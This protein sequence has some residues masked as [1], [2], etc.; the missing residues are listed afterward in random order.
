ML[1][2]T[3]VQGS[4]I[5]PMITKQ[6]GDCESLQEL[7]D[8]VV[9]WGGSF[10]PINTAAAFTKAAKLATRPA[11]HSTV[12]AGQL[13]GLLAP[14][15]DRLLPDAT[16]QGLANVLWACGKLGYRS[17]PHEADQPEA[18]V[19][20]STLEMLM[21]KLDLISCVD[22]GNA[23]YGLARVAEANRGIVPGVS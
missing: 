7:E 13:L 2:S 19:W 14:I 9:E 21:A 18:T 10:G 8:I 22:A 1:P 5:Q 12:P 16:V 20:S 6:I 11:G 4:A 17:N 23:V 3:V 15:W